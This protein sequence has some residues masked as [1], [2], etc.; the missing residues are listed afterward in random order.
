MARM[1]KV[2]IQ[3]AVDVK[4]KLIAEQEVRNQ[5]DLAAFIQVE[6][7]GGVS[8][9]NRCSDPTLSSPP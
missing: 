1:T 9:C 3:L 5:S 2:N 8:H 6:M 4:H 7:G